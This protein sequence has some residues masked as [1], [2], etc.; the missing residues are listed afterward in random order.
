MP[1]DTEHY[2]PSSP[3]SIHEDRAKH[4]LDLKASDFRISGLIASS[5]ST[6]VHV[7]F[8][9]ASGKFCF[10]K[11]ADYVAKVEAPWMRSETFNVYHEFK[12]LRQLE[13][14]GCAVVPRPVFV[15]EDEGGRPMLVSDRLGPDLKHM[16]DSPAC[17]GQEK[18]VVYKL[19]Y[20]LLSSLESLH[21]N[22]VIHRNVKAANICVG[23]RDLQKLYFVDFETAISY[24]LED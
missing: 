6:D 12:L 7:C 18:L 19:G 20:E 5:R 9:R 8:R 23:R 21:D 22:G 4:S 1:S 17:K 24:R 16:L 11:T 2:V 15:G 14:V 13:N 3:P 10:A